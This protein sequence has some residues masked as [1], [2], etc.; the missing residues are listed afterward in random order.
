MA[1]R[2]KDAHIFK[3]VKTSCKARLP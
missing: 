3:R 1:L 2:A